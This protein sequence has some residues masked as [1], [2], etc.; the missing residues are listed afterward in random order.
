MKEF[1]QRHRRAIITFCALVV[2]LFLL[3]VH[4]RPL[5]NKPT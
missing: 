3:Y 1:L 4:G 2:P 5:C